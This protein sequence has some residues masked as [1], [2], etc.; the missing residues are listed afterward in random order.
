MSNFIRVLFIF[1]LKRIENGFIFT[2]W[3]NPFHQVKISIYKKFTYIKEEEKKEGRE[4]LF[5]PNQFI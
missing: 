1:Q 5:T 4:M 2:M 3:H